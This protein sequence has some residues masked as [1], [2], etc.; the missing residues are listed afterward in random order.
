MVFDSSSQGKGLNPY[1]DNKCVVV[2]SFRFLASSDATDRRRAQGQRRGQSAGERNGAGCPWSG[3]L[4]EAHGRWR[5][6]ST[7]WDSV[8]P[9]SGRAGQMGLTSAPAVS[10]SS[11]GN[12]VFGS[13]AQVEVATHVH[14]PEALE[15]EVRT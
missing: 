12:Y 3:P 15:K 4:A 13:S 6:L 11:W 14:H 5:R 2:S 10:E 7:G 1:L 9:T 8:R